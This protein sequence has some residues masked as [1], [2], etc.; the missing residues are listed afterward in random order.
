M[1]LPHASYTV[2]RRMI[3]VGKKLALQPRLSLIASCVPKGA[4]LADIGTDHG[5]LPAYLLQNDQ[6]QY[7]IAT[8]INVEPLEHAKQ[9]AQLYSVTDRMAFRLC[10][11]LDAVDPEEVDTIVIAGMGGET[12]IDILSAAPW[13]LRDKYT[14]ILQPQ[15][16][17]ELLRSFLLEHG[18]TFTA[19]H[20]VRDKNKLYVVMVLCF[21]IPL[22][23][24][25]NTTQVDW[26]SG[27][28][29]RHDPLYGEYLDIQI[30]RLKQKDQGIRRSGATSEA[31]QSTYLLKILV[32]KKKE[33]ENEQSI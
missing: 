32:E 19:E 30:S 8:D 18:Y 21:D 25:Q 1:R 20:L 13:T 4:R 11:G 31:N 14:I 28:G 24:P 3:V 5:Y 12:I 17:I 33:W 26:W 6:I 7:A 9:T 16:K 29:L 22:D 10:S 2:G 27:I 15:T 23:I